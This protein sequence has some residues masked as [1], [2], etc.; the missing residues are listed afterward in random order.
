[1]PFA[2]VTKC[3]WQHHNRKAELYP[4]FEY[5]RSITNEAIRIGIEKSIT[6]QFG[7]H[8]ELYYRFRSEIHSRYIYGAL[9]C[10]A[11]KLKFYRK[12]KRKN[13]QV[14]IPYISKNHLIL[15]SGAYK[16]SDGQ[17]RIPIRPRQYCRIKLNHYVL[18]QIQ[19][20]KIGSVTITEDKLVIS[21]SKQVIE[22]KSTSFVAIDRN[23]DNATTY[24][25][26]DKFTRY[27]LQKANQIKQT[28]RQIKSKFKRNDVRIRERIFAKYGKKERNRVHDILHCTSKQI[29]EQ[30]MGVILED[31][32]GIRKLYRR[33]NGQGNKFRAKMNSWSFYELQ[34][35]IEY[36]ARWLGLPVRYVKASGTSSKCAACGSKM[37]PEEHRML[38][39]P[40][41]NVVIDRDI[42][43]AKNILA[44]GIRVV[45]VGTADEAMVEESKGVI[46]KVDVVQ[47][48]CQPTK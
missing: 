13:P 22:Q 4:V 48:P 39:C 26:Q 40:H 8:Y 11:S 41:C 24:D 43:A 9:G 35:Q 21:Y 1:M 36:K 45:P 28:Y 47:L 10:A 25:T 19:D 31:I 14:K 6:S 38:F 30:N 15:E 7:L 3:I 46:L 20:V 32:K 2:H 23:L 29:A 16:I 37:V 42:N 5:F 27:K 33:G 44:R 12:M 18:E 34:R 17:I